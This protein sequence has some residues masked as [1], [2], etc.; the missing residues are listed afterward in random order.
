MMTDQN[1]TASPPVAAARAVGERR[2][3]T[4]LFCDVV[5]STALAEKLD[6]EDWAD[7]MNDAFGLLTVPIQRYGGVVNKLM[8][9]GM[10]AFFGAPTAHEDDPIRAVRAGLEMHIAVEPLRAA[11]RR[12]HGIDFCVRIGINTGPV[13]VADMGASGSAESTAMGDAVNVAA[14]MEQTAVAGSVQISEDTYRLVAPLFDVEPLGRI[15]L[16][17]KSEPVAAYRVTRPSPTPG[18]LRGIRG[19]TAPLIGREPEME[20]LRAAF[21]AR[22]A[23]RGQIVCLI[24]EAGLGKSRLLAEIGAE[25]MATQPRGHWK[26]LTGVPYDTGRPFGLFQNFARQMFSVELDDHPELV[27]DKI[28]KRLREMGSSEA[29]VQLCSVAFQRVIA[30]KVLADK[31]DYPSEVIRRDIYENLYPALRDQARSEPMVLLVDDAHWADSAS[32]DLLM[33]LMRVV[34]E[35]PILFLCAFRPE[36]QSSAWRVKQMAETEFP[37]R[38]TE[39]QLKP[40]TLDDA[41]TLV[42]SLLSI[43]DLPPALRQLILRKADGNPYF[44]EEIVRTLIDD[45]VVER[46]ADGLHWRASASVDDIA[47]PDTLQALLMARIDRLDAETKATLQVASV[48]GRSFYYRILKAISDSAIALDRQLGSLE[49]VELLAECGRRPELE[50]MFRHE[51]ARDAAYGSMLNRRRR[52]FHQRVGEAI[53]AMF[54]DRIEEQAHRLAQHFGLAGDQ[55]RAARYYEMAGDTAAGVDGADEAVANYARALDAVGKVDSDTDALARLSAK[56][57]AVGGLAA[58]GGGSLHA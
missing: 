39:I 38:Y 40:L 44:V 36:R 29:E 46:T 52:E 26:A 30:A 9:D 54:A 58:A 6:P 22:D 3:I 49:R 2:V 20:R 51:L 34:D 50:Y 11:L 33:H 13:V 32:I 56:R 19:V 31:P 37:H 23:G 18:S 42:S 1:A 48:I 45:G 43:A 53:E 12:S 16:K 4:A 17:G 10:L 55:T 41:D 7:I 14:R 28:E 21:R 25:W 47:I 15:E 24:G 27:H 57:L 35:V 8:G 5:N